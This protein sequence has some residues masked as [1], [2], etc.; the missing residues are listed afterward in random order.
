MVDFL[1]PGLFAALLGIAIPLAIHLWNRKKGKIIRMGSIELLRETTHAN[2]R[3]IFF[4]ESLLFLLRMFTIILFTLLLTRPVWIFQDKPSSTSD[5]WVLIDPRLE[6]TTG[7]SSG[8]KQHNASRHV[9]AHEFTLYKVDS[10]LPLSAT[11]NTWSLLRELAMIP[12][13]P[14]SVI[15]YSYSF[16][17]DFQGKRPLLPFAT[18]WI[19]LPFDKPEQQL[20]E[21]ISSQQSLQLLQGISQE[22]STRFVSHQINNPQ[23]E[24]AIQSAPNLDTKIVYDSL[25]KQIWIKGNE[26]NKITLTTPDT[27]HFHIYADAEY[28]SYLR[29]FQAAIQA[30]NINI[31]HHIKLT[32]NRNKQDVQ[33]NYDWVAWLSDE[34][35]PDTVKYTSGLLYVDAKQQQNVWISSDPVD[36]QKYIIHASGAETTERYLDLP[37][38]LME[39]IW[40]KMYREKALQLTDMRQ[41][42]FDQILPLTTSQKMPNLQGNQTKTRE[43]ELYIWLLLCLLFIIERFYAHRKYKNN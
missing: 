13:S 19:I 3:R 8:W 7:L 4:S 15:I 30:I 12:D 23:P 38:Y 24:F 2:V 26:Q 37:R 22:Q 42:A 17:R 25:M 14:D 28:E 5:T 41:Q 36:S 16:Q 40:G 6:D 34:A 21:A 32:I 18:K 33:K 31:P 9:L 35:V 1:A 39:I 20:I 10:L 11:I 43:L 29:Y 27:T